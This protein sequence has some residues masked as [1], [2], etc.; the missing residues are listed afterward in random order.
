MKRV[1]TRIVIVGAAIL[2]IC[3]CGTSSF[4]HFIGSDPGSDLPWGMSHEEVTGKMGDFYV[5]SSEFPFLLEYRVR[6]TNASAA[7]VGVSLT[8]ATES[9]KYRFNERGL[10][11]QV[12]VS[13]ASGFGDFGAQTKDIDKRARR[14]TD[15]LLDRYGE[16]DDHSPSETDTLTLEQAVLEAAKAREGITGYSA[17]WNHAPLGTPERP[18]RVEVVYSSWEIDGGQLDHMSVFTETYTNIELAPKEK[19]VFQHVVEANVEA[20]ADVRPEE[21]RTTLAC[22]IA[23]WHSGRLRKYQYEA[24]TPLYLATEYDSGAREEI[25]AALIE[26]GADVNQP[27]TI[28]GNDTKKTDFP[29]INAVF[30]E[31]TEVAR[32]LL[33]A[34][35]DPEMTGTN[36]T[37]SSDGSPLSPREIAAIHKND[38]LLALFA[39]EADSTE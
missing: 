8:A 23:E 5:L 30:E 20:L 17:T 28:L 9:V 37:R 21:T 16:P 3:S 12:E 26:A 10:L 29:L 18:T 22:T 15:H 35:A 32:L 1:Y 2:A 24:V 25:V 6:W 11:Y 31:Q 33:D 7:R 34:G 38:D 39:D 13:Y 36:I 4:D 14:V 27:V 19:T